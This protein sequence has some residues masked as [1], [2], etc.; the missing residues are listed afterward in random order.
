MYSIKLKLFGVDGPVSF[1][2]FENLRFELRQRQ[3]FHARI[4]GMSTIGIPIKLLHESQGHIV[5]IELTNGQVY[6]GKLF[7]G[8][9]PLKS[10]NLHSGG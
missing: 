6:R 10:S 3:F 5:T 8:S 9:S 1:E 7:E 4:D 2:I